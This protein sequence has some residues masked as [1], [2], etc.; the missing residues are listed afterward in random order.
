MN[1]KKSFFI[2]SLT[3][4]LL[5]SLSACGGEPA[6]VADSP[7]ENQPTTAANLPADEEPATPQEEPTAEPHSAPTDEPQPEQPA[8]PTAQIS[9]SADV[10]PILESRCYNCHGGERIE[11]NFVMITYADLLAGG[12][13]GAVVIPGDTNASYLV[14]LILDQKMPKRGPKLTPIQMDTIITWIDQGADNN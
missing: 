5:L 8:E 2:I 13:S 1:W 9:Y 14:E 12:E 11:G 7:A 4:I 3:A 10:Q 6:P